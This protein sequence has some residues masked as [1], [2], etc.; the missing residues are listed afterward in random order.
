[1]TFQFVSSELGHSGSEK[2]HT[3]HRNDLSIT[4]EELW[5]SWLKS[6][7]KLVTEQ[8]REKRG[9]SEGKGWKDVVEIYVQYALPPSLTPSLPPSSTH[10]LSVPLGQ[11]GHDCMVG[12]PGRA[13]RLL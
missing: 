11:Q 13:V 3:L 5:D 2:S 12:E 4:F 9:G 7:G 8:R 10:P 1:M 6:E